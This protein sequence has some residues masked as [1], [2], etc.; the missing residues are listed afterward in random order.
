MSIYDNYCEIRDKVAQAA[1]SSGRKPESVKVIS[2]SKTFP[3]SDIN[4]AIRS[5]ITLFGENRVQEA[6]EKIP[7]LTGSAEFH[8]IGHLQSNKAKDAVKLFSMIHS[9]DKSDTAQKVDREAAA[10]GKVQNILIQVNTSGEISKSGVSPDELPALIEK[11]SGLQNIR[12]FGL[13]TIGPMTDDRKSVQKSF[14]DL[15]LLLRQ[16]NERFGLSMTELSMGMS[17]DFEL[18]VAEGATL[19]RIGSAIF[20]KRSYPV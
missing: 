16:V 1:V 7:F 17:G 11:I 15:A 12:P 4:E 5:G 19:V 14:A 10:I 2:V 18:A 6:K 9:I 13:M 8:L 3:L 20:G